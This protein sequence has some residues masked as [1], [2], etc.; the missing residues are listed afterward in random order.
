[1]TFKYV[2]GY[3]FGKASRYYYV[4]HSII[5]ADIEPDKLKFMANQIPR[6]FGLI[7]MYV[8]IPADV[9]IVKYSRSTQYEL[10]YAIPGTLVMLYNDIKKIITGLSWVPDDV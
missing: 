4:A 6:P 7:Y 5:A 8:V 2:K 1:M 3:S 9:V 10:S